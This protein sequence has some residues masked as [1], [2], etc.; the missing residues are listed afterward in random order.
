MKYKSVSPKW[1]QTG[2]IWRPDH[3][4]AV[5]WNVALLLAGSNCEEQHRAH[6]LAVNAHDEKQGRVSPVDDLVVPLLHEGALQ[7][8]ARCLVRY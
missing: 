1:P 8:K 5:V 3:S 7:E 4:Q 6:L 2:V